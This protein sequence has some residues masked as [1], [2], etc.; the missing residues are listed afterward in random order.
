MSRFVAECPV[1]GC[2]FKKESHWKN[3]ARGG[4][5][6]HLYQTDG[7]GHGSRGSPPEENFEIQV[8]RIEE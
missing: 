7:K 4:V 1:D 3:A 6:L 5:V 8:E 2:D